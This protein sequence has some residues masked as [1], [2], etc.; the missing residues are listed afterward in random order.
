MATLVGGGCAGGSQVRDRTGRGGRSCA[1]GR[2]NR[3]RV[4]KQIGSPIR[5]FNAP[6]SLVAK[7]GPSRPRADALRRG[8][9]AD[10]EG[11]GTAPATTRFGPSSY[12]TPRV[13][14][15]RNLRVGSTGLRPGYGR[16]SASLV[17]ERLIGSLES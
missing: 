10:V 3:P 12:V 1:R 4:S 13:T 14:P 15:G 11:L 17:N 8:G 5:L 7:K 9:C 16:G 6:R 2:F